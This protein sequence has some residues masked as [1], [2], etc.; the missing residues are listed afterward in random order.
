MSKEALSKS[1][2]PK[3]EVFDSLYDGFMY[4]TCA[5]GT[6][7]AAN[8]IFR[9]AKPSMKLDFADVAKF[10]SYITSGVLMVDYAKY[11]CWIPPSIA[12][13]P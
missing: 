12:P 10:G 4:T 11:K 9:I 8:V 13:K 5:F 6:G 7:F 2:V 3:K 1:W